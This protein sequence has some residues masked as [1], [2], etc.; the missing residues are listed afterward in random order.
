MPRPARM[1]RKLNDEQR[2]LVFKMYAEGIGAPEM[3][4]WIKENWDI[5]YQPDSIYSVVRTER[6]QPY[7]KKFKEQYLA[8]VKEVPIANKRIRVDDLELIRLKTVKLLKENP[9]ET[10]AQREEF[11][12]MVRTLND[13]IS[14][15][16]EE[17]EKKPFINLGLGDFTDKTDDELI[18]ERNEL[19]KNAERLVR[20]TII[21]A[22]SSPEGTP[23]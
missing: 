6:A 2:L 8:R 15:A 14:N 12:F 9:C 23:G 21:E 1:E 11:R 4:K 5:V 17:M 19:L 16:R 13:T 18:A 3:S 20:G 7:L 22:S 10:K